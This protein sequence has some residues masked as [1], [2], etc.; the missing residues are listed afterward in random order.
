MKKKIWIIKMGGQALVNKAQI[1]S[2]MSAIKTLIHMG[3]FIVVVHGGGP[4]AD[5]MQQK[6]GIPVKKINGRRITDKE[7]LK[8]VKMVYAGSINKD[9]VSCAVKHHI[10]AV[11]ISG[12]DAQLA[13]V[14]KK[15]I[16]HVLA[17][18][19]DFGYVGDIES[20]QAGIL[21]VLLSNNYLPIIACLGIDDAGEIFNIN[22]DTLATSIA[23]EM[24]AEKLIFITDVNGIAAYKG[25][26]EY[27]TKLSLV[28][29]KNM[30]KNGNIT[31][32]MI[33]KIENIEIAIHNGLQSVQLVGGLSNTHQ[34]VDAF[35][36]QKYG[37][38]IY[39]GNY[40]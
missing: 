33:P 31:D 25:S 23:C 29:A 14:S 1:D 20:I 16:Q 5:E 32:G 30:I 9:L 35:Q 8:V 24:H 26:T 34:W 4:Q 3:V 37:T 21:N 38:I 28:E 7:T 22:A 17:K 15:P 11:G 6:L 2:L 18:S 40:E 39:G 27:F 10:P 19:V 36:K 13:L 12:I